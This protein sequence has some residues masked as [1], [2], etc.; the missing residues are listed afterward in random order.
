M[1]EAVSWPLASGQRLR[2]VDCMPGKNNKFLASPLQVSMAALTF[3]ALQSASLCLVTTPPERMAAAIGKALSP[4]SWLGL[5]VKELVLTVLLALRFM[6]TVG[7]LLLR[8]IEWQSVRLGVGGRVDAVAIVSALLIHPPC[9]TATS[10]N[11][12][13]SSLTSWI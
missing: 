8:A 1:F 7:A 12:V 13:S 11:T 10:S 4:L 3:T 6:G 2:L 9:M 5:P